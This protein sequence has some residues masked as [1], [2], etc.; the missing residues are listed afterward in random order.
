[1]YPLQKQMLVNI[2]LNPN[3]NAGGT[4]PIYPSDTTVWFSDIVHHAD[5]RETFEELVDGE[6]IIFSQG[7][8]DCLVELTQKGIDYFLTHCSDMTPLDI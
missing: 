3:T 7:D 2:A 5:D 8:N 1:M 6:Y 4:C